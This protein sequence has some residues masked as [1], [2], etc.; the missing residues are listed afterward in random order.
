MET[1]RVILVVVMGLVWGS[2]LNVVIYRLPRELS[3]V[4]P[5]SSCPKCGRRIKWYDN[6]PVL[7]YLMLGGKCRFC[8]EKIS[9]VYPAV[10]ALTAVCFVII[11]FHNLRFFDLQFFTDCLFVS[12]LIALG[13]I[14]FFH[15]VIPDHISLPVMIMA[16]VYAPFRFDLNL[17][18]A[19]IGAAVGGGFLFVV[20]LVYLL[21]RKKEGLGMGDVMMMLMVGAY[22][23]LGR[24][25]LTLLLASVVGAIFGLMLM[26]FR[27]KDMKFALPFG[28]FIAPAAFV[29][30]VWGHPLIAWYLSLFPN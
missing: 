11:Y 28:S 1:L 4:R 14:D 10:E 13:F 15:Q 8:G 19:L 16:L 27:G 3:L 21:W 22:L 23:G 6:I 26:K 2:F 9:T 30:L 24:T 29:A 5:P 25:I 17:R 12:A 20:Y 18:Q 7:S